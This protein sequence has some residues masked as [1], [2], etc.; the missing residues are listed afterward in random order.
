MHSIVV[1]IYSFLCPIVIMLLITY[2]FSNKLKHSIQQ[3]YYTGNGTRFIENITFI[4]NTPVNNI[5]T[6]IKC[7]KNVI[8]NELIINI[9]I[10]NI[11]YDSYTRTINL[12]CKMQNGYSFCITITCGIFELIYKET[13]TLTMYIN[14]LILYRLF[15][16]NK[17]YFNYPYNNWGS[18]SLNT[19]FDPFIICKYSDYFSHSRLHLQCIAFIIKSLKSSIY[20][21]CNTL[22]KENNAIRMRV[23]YFINTLGCDD[24]TYQYQY[25]KHIEQ[26]LIIA[27]EEDMKY[28]TLVDNIHKSFTQVYP[29]LTDMINDSFKYIISNVPSS[30]YYNDNNIITHKEG[31]KKRIYYLKHDNKSLVNIMYS[32][33]QHQIRIIMYLIGINTLIK[34]LRAIILYDFLFLMLFPIG[35][36]T[37]TK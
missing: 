12:H 31:I 25:K 7:V 15:G 3:V 10:V 11:Q 9:A 6:I 32:I 24:V 4:D 2:L 18:L 22:N 20:H 19:L 36:P 29:D 26:P 14:M 1:V 30:F 37:D 16:T 28:F 21:N 27:Y 35:E 8:D 5:D 17:N 23:D 33:Y 13:R 34:E